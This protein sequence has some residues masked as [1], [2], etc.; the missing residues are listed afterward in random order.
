MIATAI[1]ATEAVE[2]VVK[3]GDG[4]ILDSGR[5]TRRAAIVVV[6]VVAAAVIAIVN[7]APFHGR[8]RGDHHGE[9]S[10]S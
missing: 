7:F 9:N 3:V 2:M 10:T 5:V 4:M 8:I 1:V 6:V